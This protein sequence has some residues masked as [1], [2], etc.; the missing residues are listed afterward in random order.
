MDTK[1]SRRN[2]LQTA[3]PLIAG[4]AVADQAAQAAVETPAPPSPAD[5]GR[6]NSGDLA[7]AFDLTA[8]TREFEK[9]TPRGKTDLQVQMGD[10]TG[11]VKSAQVTVRGLP[12]G[13]YEVRY[14]GNSQRMP[15][16]DVMTLQVP[17]ASVGQVAIRRV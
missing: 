17:I 1:F 6:I 10:S 8:A 2:L 11:L 7:A 3:T 16:T 13:T 9:V 12:A 14:S 5:L 15:E 4:A